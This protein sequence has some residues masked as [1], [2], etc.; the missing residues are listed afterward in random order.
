MAI[1][2]RKPTPEENREARSWPVWTKEPSSFDW[3][4]DRKETC[5]IL[6]GNATVEAEGDAVRF[7]AG[8]WVVF[9]QGLR[10][11]WNISEGI[12]KYYKF[13]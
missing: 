9:P 13:R 4:Y 12:R 3:E 2:V 7:G 6:E 10:C 5:L 1:E 11:V 8:D